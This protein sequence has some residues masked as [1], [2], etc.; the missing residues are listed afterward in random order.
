[1]TGAL[2][3]RVIFEGNGRAVG[4]EFE[5]EGEREAVQREREVIL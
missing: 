3:R 1:M 4:M 5:H 2:T